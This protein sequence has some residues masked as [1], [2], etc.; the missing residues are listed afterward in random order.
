MKRLQK[1]NDL[2]YQKIPLEWIPKSFEKEGGTSESMK[3]RRIL[4]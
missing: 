2:G 3:K 4:N 1:K